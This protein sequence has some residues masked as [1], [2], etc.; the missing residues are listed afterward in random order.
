M[1]PEIETF[2][3]N[4]KCD[5]WSLGIILYQLFTNEYI[6]YSN[7]PEEINDNRKKEKL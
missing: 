3:Y 7:N 2:H 1:A 5:L 4:N 6:F